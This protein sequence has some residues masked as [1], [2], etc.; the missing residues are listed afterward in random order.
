MDRDLQE[1][2]RSAGLMILLAQTQTEINEKLMDHKRNRGSEYLQYLSRQPPNLVGTP[3]IIA[4]KI[5]E[6]LSYDVDH[7]I[8][9]WHFGD[10]LE[11]IKL[12]KD[13][14]MNKI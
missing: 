1:I 14:V 9:R 3:D 8:L 10:E 12:F 5:S 13:E 11:S 7:F 2:R 4:E 6:Y